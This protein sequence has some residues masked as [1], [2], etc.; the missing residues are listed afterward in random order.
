MKNQKLLHIVTM[1]LVI[2]GALNWGLIGLLD[3]NVV[4]SAFGAVP[5]VEQ[6]VY[7]LVGVSALYVLLT[8][9]QDCKV[10][11]RKK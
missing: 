3:M 11:G 4:H 5:M 7:V 8:H 1:S 10:C 6:W 9:A 2:V